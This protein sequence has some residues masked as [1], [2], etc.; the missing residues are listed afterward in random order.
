[1]YC[2]L[3]YYVDTIPTDNLPEQVLHV[4]ELFSS[5][6]EISY[7]HISYLLFNPDADE[8]LV[9]QVFSF[10]DSGK[11]EFAQLGIIQSVGENDR[12]ISAPF[13]EACSNCRKEEL[14]SKSR[15]QIQF[16]DYSNIMVIRVDYE[17]RYAKKLCFSKYKNIVIGLCNLGFNVNNSFYHVYSRKNNAVTLDGGQ[18]GSYIGLDGWQNKKDW[19]LHQKNHYMNHLMGVHCANSFPS[20]LITSQIKD[21]ISKIVGGNNI[22]VVNGTVFFSLPNLASVT[23]AYRILSKLTIEK[24]T[25]LLVSAIQN[26]SR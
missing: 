16:P 2:S 22:D 26:Q 21:A 10:D 13:I 6:L 12:I 4:F 17:Q 5:E 23:S 1:M 19:L 14:Y 18:I 24:L 11:K 3:R 9:N 15:V 20:S 7:D 8:V 25:N